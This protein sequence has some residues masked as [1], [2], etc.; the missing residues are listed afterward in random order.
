MWRQPRPCNEK[1]K[2]EKPATI[3][4]LSVF[5]YACN[6][7]GYSEREEGATQLHCR[8]N[9]LLRENS[10]VC[11]IVLNEEKWRP[12][13]RLRTD[14]I[15]PR[16]QISFFPQQKLTT[17]TTVWAHSPLSQQVLLVLYVIWSR[18]EWMGI[19]FKA[20]WLTPHLAIMVKSTGTTSQVQARRRLHY[21]YEN[22]HGA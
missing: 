20:S 11:T 7:T 10:V 4:S 18:M 15:P 3:D 14:S 22:M 21:Y 13:K 1:L 2:Y 9:K 17:H 5:Q 6:K 8:M 16:I 19:L 12:S